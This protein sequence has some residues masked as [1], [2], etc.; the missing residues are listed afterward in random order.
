M[1][2]LSRRS[3]TEIV[4]DHRVSQTIVPRLCGCCEG[5]VDSIISL[6]HS[7]IGQ[8]STWSW[9]PCTSQSDKWLMIYSREKAK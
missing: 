3:R 8:A 5:A 1:G 2:V 9:R 4:F 6:L 7:Y